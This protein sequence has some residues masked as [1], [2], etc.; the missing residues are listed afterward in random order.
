MDGTLWGRRQS[1]DADIWLA[2]QYAQCQAGGARR[3]KNRGRADGAVSLFLYDP[4][5]HTT[6]MLRNWANELQLGPSNAYAVAIHDDGT[7]WSRAYG[8][9]HDYFARK[10]ELNTK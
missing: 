8:Q 9:L 7:L 6:R 2:E 10:S 5:N 1:L 3:S 4:G